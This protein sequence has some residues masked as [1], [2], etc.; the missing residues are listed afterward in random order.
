MANHE[1][2][3][4]WRKWDL[5]VHTPASVVQDY[6][7]D[8]DSAWERY[9]ADL[10]TLPNEFAVIGVNDYFFL[11]GYRKLLEFKQQ[12]R[13]NNIETLLPVIEFR[14]AKFAGHDKMLRVNF[15]LIFSEQLDPDII[16]NQFLVQLRS[17]LNISAEHASVSKQW[18]AA[19]TRASL[20][21]LGRLI[22]E[23]MPPD[24]LDELTESDFL[25]GF[26]NLNFDDRRLYE[27]LENSYLRGKYITAVGKAEWDQYRWNDHS[28]AEKKNI[29][30]SVDAVFTAAE[31]LSMFER[32]RGRLQK[33][34]VNARLF[35]CSDAHAF[36]GSQEKD[37][38]GNC[39]TWIKAD[40]TLDG[41]IL[42]IKDYGERVFVGPRPAVLDDIDRH[43]AKYIRRVRIDRR[44]DR[45]PSGKWF[46]G[47]DISLNPGLVTIIGNRG[48]GKS[49]LLDAIALAGNSPRPAEDLSFLGPFQAA[50][51]NLADNFA[52]SLDWYTSES[53]ETVP[54]SSSYVPTLPSR[55]KHLPQHFI[56]I[57]CNEEAGQFEQEIE[58]V[59]FSHVRED[60]RLE[61]HSLTELVEYRSETLRQSA[62]DLKRE[63]SVLNVH[64]ATLEE[65]LSQTHVAQLESLLAQRIDE[66]RGIWAK[67]PAIPKAPKSS[68]PELDKKIQ[69]L[70][71]KVE[72]LMLKKA[73]AEKR[74]IA[75]RAAV[76]AARRVLAIIDR[77][78]KNL[79]RLSTESVEDF[80]KIG[81]EF[82]KVI[83]LDVKRELVK[84]RET[85]LT[86]ELGRLR[87]S[88]DPENAESH[89]AMLEESRKELKIVEAEL[90][91]P[92]QAY[93]SDQDTRSKF[94]K[95]IRELIGSAEISD[96]IRFLR[97]RLA[98]LRDSAPAKLAGLE[99]ARMA[100]AKELFAAVAGH[101]DL[102][103]EFYAPVQGFVDRYPPTD[104]SFRV[105]FSAS[106]EAIQFEEE[107]SS[108]VAHNRRGSFYGAE[109]SHQRLEELIRDVDFNEWSSV[110]AFLKSVTDAFHFDKRAG[111][112]SAR[113]Q[114]S[115]QIRP[116]RTVAELYDF[117][118]HLTYIRYKH[119]L[120]MGE[121]PLNLLSSG[122]KGA[123]LLV[124]YL[125]IDQSDCPL[126]IDQPEENLDNQS[127]F[128][129]MVPFMREARRRRQV[130][131]I[132]HNPNIAVVAGADQ[133]IFCAM[134]KRDGFRLS[135]VS[136]ALENPEI[137]QHVLDV[138]EGTRPAFSNRGKTYRISAYNKHR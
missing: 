83:S 92:L 80:S 137:N 43:P 41:L 11:D 20:E 135:Y 59:V 16:E 72:Q 29:I 12:G 134:D 94:I 101:V 1:I 3:S 37:R 87:V 31:D 78:E 133:V 25:L 27:L 18:N 54:L 82:G 5:H 97:A 42:A 77:L 93:K 126:L 127:V 122:E 47:L 52:V 62:D 106:L 44:P 39:L 7:G 98:I 136:G 48:M 21:D 56:D 117:L 75:T 114:V 105:A 28:I 81:L 9:I 53:T 10:E 85:E 24:R 100:R 102:L 40:P 35:D 67:R 38:L 66:L 138:L 45:S 65:E 6:G 70:R 17:G 51:G 19:V 33:E 8:S 95:S 4:V 15:H 32:G 113:R 128:K 107:L 26:N 131:L 68:D 50:R 49:A 23:D 2:G 108:R 109:Q 61:C 112:N 57:L 14:L 125:L 60:E 115:E 124:F 46:D 130:F 88:V 103:E 99:N 71:G 73:D 121:R 63:I 119:Q 90:S 96:T 22:K 64:I 111:E 69:E 76:E 118:Y 120:T 104:D 58:R 30:N 36:S 132:T 34:G 116:G 79:A 123:L 55:V 84:C 89:T 13:L 91:A 129:T 110:E 86:S 74:I